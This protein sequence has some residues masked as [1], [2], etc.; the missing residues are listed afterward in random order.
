MLALYRSGRQAD[1]LETYR[2]ARRRLV[3]ELGLEPGR[4]LQQLERAILAQDPALDAPARDAARRPP[5]IAR[6]TAARRAFDRRGEEGL[7]AALIAVA[8]SLSGSGASTI[9]AAPNSLVAI[10][11]GSNGVVG[12]VP[13][14]VRPGAVAFGSGSLW[15]ANLDDQTVSRI[16][17]STLR[18][19]RTITVTGPPTGIATSPGGIWVVESNPNPD[20]SGGVLGRPRGPRSSTRSAPRADRQCRPER[21]GGD[22]G[23]RQLG[24]G[25][26]VHR[27]ADAPQPGDGSK[28]AATRSEC[29]SGRD[30]RRRRGRLADRQRGRQRHPGGR[31]RAARRRSRSA[32]RRAGSRSAPAASGSPTRAMTRSSGSIPDTRAVTATIP[33]GR[34]PAG[35]PS[36]PGRCGS[37]T[38][39]TAP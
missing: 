26:T 16:D 4:E 27:P 21:P 10:D 3:E 34:S 19:M 30:R 25:R 38:A 18:T 17:P 8:V 31:D 37:P 15:V 23:P 36:A 35:V 6:G 1:A 13:V 32:T 39:A 11:P 2:G 12:A 9:R 7:L 20:R 14:G 5:A 28:G 33:V 24:L 29:H 22:C